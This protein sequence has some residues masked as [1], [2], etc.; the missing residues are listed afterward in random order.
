MAQ[1]RKIADNNLLREFNVNQSD[2]YEKP[3]FDFDKDITQ[4][5]QSI[6]ESLHIIKD[7]LNETL[8]T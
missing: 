6:L 5:T 3:L 7:D 1:Q 2:K 4:Q 8:H